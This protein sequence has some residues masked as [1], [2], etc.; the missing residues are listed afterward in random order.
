ME[1]INEL[2]R[3]E[4]RVLE[5]QITMEGRPTMEPV[6]EPAPAKPKR[7][8]APKKK[9]INYKVE[10]K[11][12]MDANAQLEEELNLVRNKAEILFRELSMTKDKLDSIEFRYE[13]ANNL[14]LDAVQNAFNSHNLTLRK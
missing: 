3:D 11:K 6:P 12:A 14:L 9:E 10:H 8:P 13:Q 1:N 5:G 2:D 4:H 7:K